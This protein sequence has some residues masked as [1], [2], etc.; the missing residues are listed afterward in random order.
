MRIHRFADYKGD[1]NILFLL[2]IDKV[3][4]L[5]IWIRAAVL[6]SAVSANFL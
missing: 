6:G 2:K 4:L 1:F 5:M 3:I